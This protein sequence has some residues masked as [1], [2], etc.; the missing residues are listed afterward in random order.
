M[1]KTIDKIRLLKKGAGIFILEF[2]YVFKKGGL[3]SILSY[4]KLF[5]TALSG[6]K[7][8]EYENKGVLFFLIPPIPSPGFK[9]HLRLYTDRFILKDYNK[10][11]GQ[12]F[13]AVNRKCPF[14]CWY[15]SAGN[16]PDNELGL[17]DIDRIIEI[18]KN[19]G[20]ST[21]VF[22]GGEPLLRNDIDELILKYSKDLSFVILTSG[23]GLNQERARR[24][25]RNGLFAISISLDHYEKKI[26]DRNRGVDGAFEIALNAIK[27]AKDAGLYTVIQTVVTDALIQNNSIKRFINFVEKLD[28]DE[29]FL[30]EPLC[31]G[32][33]FD[34]KR[35]IFLKED[36][37]NMLKSLHS[38]SDKTNGTLKIITSS[39]IEDPEKYG[40]GAGT[41][42][43][44]VDTNGELWPCNFLPISLGNI[45]VEPNLVRARLNKY[46]G[47][48]CSKCILKEYRQ[49][50]LN[51]Y[52]NKLPLS[53]ESIE[54]I[55]KKRLNDNDR[56]P[57]FFR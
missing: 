28:A 47:K 6:E 41:Q 8:V 16:S 24:L 7:I 52:N 29:L 3:N 44:Y 49:E 22:T 36:K 2:F 33:L 10:F 43:I 48:P 30:L 40:C 42:H 15:C 51:V 5:K 25:K 45:L 20:V 50:F 13:I 53:F 56:P 21:I 17:N 23:Y 54:H 31:T 14:N 55:L 19:W 12:A 27:N 38:R 35:Q 46:F 18:F 32:R 11:V 37:I 39:H 34:T 1:A 57:E 9:R 4:F 26:N